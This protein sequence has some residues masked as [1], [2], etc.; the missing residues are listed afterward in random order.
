MKLLLKAASRVLQPLGYRRL[1]THF[2]KTENGFH[3][4][5]D[6]QRS[7]HGAYFFVNVCVH[8]VGLPKLLIGKLVIPDEPKEYEC[9]LRRRIQDLVPAES[10]AALRSQSVDFDDEPEVQKVLSLIPS[11]VEPW[12]AR[13]GSYATIIKASDEELK[14]MLTVVPKLWQKAC[15]MLKLFCCLK[16]KDRANADRF[17]AEFIAAPT[18]GSDLSLVDEYILSLAKEQIGQG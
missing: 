1:A 10:A 17:L 12:L 16:M 6:F 11:T 18:G 7:A 15:A 14:D 4:V 2:Q 9:I 5:I 13:W 8:P 3:R